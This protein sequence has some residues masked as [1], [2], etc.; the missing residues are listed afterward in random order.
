MRQSYSKKSQMKINEMIFMI[1]ALV[2]FFAIVLMF[3]LSISL[4]GL[5]DSVTQSSRDKSIMLVSQLADSPELSCGKSKCIDAD[6]LLIIANH[7]L[8]RAFWDV[9]GLVVEK[10]TNDNKTV[11]CNL[12][13]YPKCNTIILKR[14]L[15]NTI[16]DSSIVSL[17]MKDSKNGYLYDKCEMA[18]IMVWSKI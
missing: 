15:N 4:S 1:I 11:E 18:R 7:P 12:G 8:Y 5:K 17:C 2:I 14:P 6:K 13:N 16:P 10:I 3:Y 9:S